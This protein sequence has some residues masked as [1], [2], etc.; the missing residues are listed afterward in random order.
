MKVEIGIFTGLPVNLPVKLFY[1]FTSKKYLP[2]NPNVTKFATFWDDIWGKL[3]N[4][5]SQGT[6]L[7]SK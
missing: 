3:V 6:A 2:V 4:L 1:Q 7:L 5:T